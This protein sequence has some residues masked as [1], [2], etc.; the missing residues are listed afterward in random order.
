MDNE[1]PKRRTRWQAIAHRRYPKLV[2]MGGDGENGICWV[3]MAKCPHAEVKRW[4]Y[5]LAPGYGDAEAIL[6]HWRTDGC[7][8]TH[9]NPGDHSLWRIH[10][11]DI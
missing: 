10:E 3:V 1:K 9:C 11:E 4:R 8:G 2:F 7:G 5:R 6:A